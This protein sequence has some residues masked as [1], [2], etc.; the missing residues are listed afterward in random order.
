[1]LVVGWLPFSMDDLHKLLT[2]VNQ[3]SSQFLKRLSSAT[4]PGSGTSQLATGGI[5]VLEQ[6]V[7]LLKQYGNLQ[8]KI[9]AEAHQNTTPS[10]I[11][12]QKQGIK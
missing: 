4:N 8:G 5:T 11:K 9:L 2:Q 3:L 7:D 6:A 12:V 10:R 1:M